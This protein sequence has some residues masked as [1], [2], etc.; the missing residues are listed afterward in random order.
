MFMDWKAFPVGS[1]HILFSQ[2]HTMCLW[3][4]ALTCKLTWHFYYNSW[5][6]TFYN[7][8][9][10]SGERSCC[11]KNLVSVCT[12]KQL[13]GGISRG[14]TNIKPNQNMS[15]SD[16]KCSPVYE[17]WLNHSKWTFSAKISEG[18]HCIFP[19]VSELVTW[20]AYFNSLMSS[21]TES[22]WI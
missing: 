7:A 9:L 12:L 19:K 21:L 4:F 2:N 15:I 11:N 22:F 1:R 8:Y 16:W 14:F 5:Y 20:H 6:Q 3:C 18:G 10:P 17:Y 13:I